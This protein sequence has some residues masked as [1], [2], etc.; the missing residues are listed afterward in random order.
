VRNFICFG[1]FLVFLLAYIQMLLTRPGMHDNVM[2]MW[3]ELDS[4][5]GTVTF[6][7]LIIINN[8]SWKA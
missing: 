8:D 7:G 4:S 3:L 2:T 5:S 6:I 1:I